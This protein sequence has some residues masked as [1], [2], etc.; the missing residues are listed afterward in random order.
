MSLRLRHEYAVD[1]PRGLPAGNGKPTQEFPADIAD[2]CA[3]RPAQIRQVRAGVYWRDV[4]RRFLAYS[5]PSRSP[6]PRHLAVLATSRLCQG[7]SRPP[8]HHPDQAALS[9]T[10]SLRRG[11]RRRSPTSTRITAPHGATRSSDSPVEYGLR[12]REVTWWVAGCQPFHTTG[13]GVQAGGEVRVRVRSAVH[14]MLGR[15][16]G[17]L[18][19]VG[20]LRETCAGQCSRRVRRRIATVIPSAPS[21]TS[22][23]DDHHPSRL[24]TTRRSR[25]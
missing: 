11:K 17:R 3:P 15:V 25:P 8:R 4:K 9:S 1:L 5:S 21:L 24:K 23:V 6:D 7:C 2:G 19:G 13:D 18:P 12:R 10:P 14:P 16:V 22:W 20:V